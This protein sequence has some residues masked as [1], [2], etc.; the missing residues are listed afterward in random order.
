M[1]FLLIAIALLIAVIIYWYLIK[2]RAKQKHL[3]RFNVTNN[4]SKEKFYVN[5]CI[6]K[7]EN[8]D[9]LKEI[10]ITNRMCYYFNDIIK[11]EE[12]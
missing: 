1:P 10:D 6:I 8:N 3:L 11:I 2:Y 9:Q 5:K 12:T 7:I 4:K